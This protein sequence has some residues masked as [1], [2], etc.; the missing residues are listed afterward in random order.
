MN[1]VRESTP[2]T[3]VT[4]KSLFAR[5]NARFDLRAYTMII[6]LVVIWL[7]FTVLTEGRF[8]TP[9]NLSNLARQV[10]ITAILAIGM[11]MVIVT[12]HI[13]LSVGSVLGLTGGIASILQVW[14]NV[15]TPVAILVALGFGVLIGAFHGYWV[16][17]HNVPAFIVTLAGL[18][19]YRG[20]LLG[21]TKG[22]TVAPLDP[23]FKILSSGYLSLVPGIILTSIIIIGLVFARI[24]SRRSKL[25]YGFKVLPLYLEILTIILYCGLIILAT[26]VLYQYEGIPY[27]VIIVLVLA[28]IF[29]FITN[30]TKFGRQVYAMGGN[31]EAARLSGI[32]VRRRT[33]VVFIL[34]GFLASIAG[35]LTTARLNAGTITAGDGAELDAIASCVI[36]GTSFLGGIG[37]IPGAVLGALVMAS[38]DNGM[39]MMN[40]EAYWQMIIKG[41]ILLL[42]VWLDI[43]TKKNR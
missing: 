34:A 9:R 31:I 13:E 32:N 41:A 3:S 40:T 29:S 10:S 22:Q 4:R 18:L 38:I 35:V 19:A 20:V 14:H 39:S 27:P 24:W 28:V 37:S 30:N 8:L 21:I 33:L 5:L 6:A 25:K 17:Y 15:S 11:V 36:G 16:A 26:Y 23:S 2:T 43:K 7:L 42:A 1:V 12:T